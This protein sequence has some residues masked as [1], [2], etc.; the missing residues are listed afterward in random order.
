MGITEKLIMRAARLKHRIKVQR[1]TATQDSTGFPAKA[2]TTL[3]TCWGAVEA[4]KAIEAES[5]SELIS[6]RKTT[7]IIRYSSEVSSVDEKDRILFGTRVFSI[8]YVTLPSDRSIPSAYI[9]LKCIEG[10][11]DGG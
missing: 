5:A 11:K 6:V 1:F 7:I 9:E 8:E 4:D 2:W 3:H 10:K